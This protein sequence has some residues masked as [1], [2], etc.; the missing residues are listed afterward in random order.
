VGVILLEKQWPA[1]RVERRDVEALIP[2]ARN[3]RTHSDEQVSQ[4]AASVREWGWTV[5]VLVDGEGGIIAGHG[6]VLAAKKLGLKDIPVMVAIGWSEG[7]KRAYILAD[8]KL[9]EN[10]GWDDKLLRIEVGELKALDF[11][12]DLL[13]F[14]EAE[15]GKL[16]AAPAGAGDTDA[17][18]K[19]GEDLQYQIVIKCRDE[20]HQT[21]LLDAFEAQGLD[22][23][24]LIS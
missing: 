6:R 12:M 14:S 16:S 13:G 7:Q 17:A 19:L 21:E 11:K 22:C 23:R 5:P 24:T 18:P 3:A 4:I 15:L 8:N 2:Y 9:P 20:L 1:D 10:A